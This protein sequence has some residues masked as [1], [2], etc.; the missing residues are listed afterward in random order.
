MS[1]KLFYFILLTF[2]VET[3]SVSKSQYPRVLLYLVIF[4]FTFYLLICFKFLRAEHYFCDC[5][6]VSNTARMDCI[7]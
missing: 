4:A 2:R 6:N 5:L 1:Y 3:R 7:R